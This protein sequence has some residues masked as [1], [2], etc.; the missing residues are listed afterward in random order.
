MNTRLPN[1][2][3]MGLAIALPVAGLRSQDDVQTDRFQGAG[4]ELE[5][6]LRE[7]VE[8]L[9]AERKRIAELQLPLAARVTE[10]ENALIAIRK[11]FLDLTR[12][13]DSRVNDVNN[14]R[15]EVEQRRAEIGYL[16]NSLDDYVRNF[17]AR[18][19]ITEL[20]RYSKDLETVKLAPESPDLTQRE[21]FGVQAGLLATS[22]DRLE[23]L[24]GGA[25]F[26][27]SAVA[28][29]GLVSSGNFVVFGPV[30]LFGAERGG[31][32]GLAEQRLGSTEPTVIPYSDPAHT[33]L[34]AE[35]VRTG[36]GQ[37]PLDA[38][39][40]NAFKIEQTNETWLEHVK[41]GG[42]VMIPIFVLAGLALL[43]A[44][45]KWLTLSL[46]RRPSKRQVTGLLD[47]V[48]QRDQE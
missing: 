8:E 12:Q 34:A 1:I 28:P 46:I 16:S 10:S 48:R 7:S 19:H 26:A 6:R 47:A 20:Q 18:L 44:L 33:A 29:N 5:Q 38:S 11:E 31:D 25:K 35:L 30:A 13:L 14:L 45:W 9:N 3:V 42:V 41:A 32:V 36:E 39:L 15:K 23:D 24:L 27:G 17:E 40:G 2:V 4:A 37:L 21:I 43:V 22:L